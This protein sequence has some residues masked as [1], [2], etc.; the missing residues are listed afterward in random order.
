MITTGISVFVAP[1]HLAGDEV[2]CSIVVEQEN[3]E[4]LLL[5]PP[6]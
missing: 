1:T 3:L 4:A 5:K 2:S 6:P